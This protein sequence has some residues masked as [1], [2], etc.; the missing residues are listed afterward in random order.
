MMENM[1]QLTIDNQ[2]V[3]ALE[4]TTIY[5][6]ALQNGIKIPTLCFHEY[7]TANALCR[8]CVV[9]VQGSR[10]LIPACVAKISEGMIVRTSTDRV[11]SARNNSGDACRIC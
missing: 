1:I 6:A 9:E 5:H 8:I 4:G 7:C 3:S 10:T 11:R 2:M